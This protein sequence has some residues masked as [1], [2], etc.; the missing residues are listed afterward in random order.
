MIDISTIDYSELDR[1]EVL[2]Y[3]FYPRPESGHPDSVKGIENL[4]IPVGGSH[5]LG[6]A[7]HMAAKSDP[8]ILFFHGNGEIVRDYDDIGMMYSR[9]NINFMPVDYRGY[10]RSTGT[11]TVTNMMRDCH[12]IFDFTITLLKTGGCSGPLIVM[13]RSLGSAS[14]V[15][16]ASHYPEDI[17]GL[18]VES[19]FSSMAGLYERLGIHASI[20]ANKRKGLSNT[21][22]ISVFTKPTLIIHAEF[23]HIIPFSAGRNLYNA[24]GASDKTLLK[25]PGANH[26]D[27]FFRGREAYLNAIVR[28]IDKTKAAVSSRN[29]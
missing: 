15:E 6:A 4:Q 12:E 1:P 19:G 5:V 7:I 26:N 16:L 2:G 11:P 23:D 13:G 20:P 28:L 25:I 18:I 17:D 3:L 29:L 21:D 8:T 27:L 24:A 9:L 14:A 10:G 22:K